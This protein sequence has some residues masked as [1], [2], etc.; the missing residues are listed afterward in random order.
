MSMKHK[1][2]PQFLGQQ[3]FDEN[4]SLYDEFAIE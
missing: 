4:E 2:L 3:D 1:V